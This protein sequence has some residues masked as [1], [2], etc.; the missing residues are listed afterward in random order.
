MNNSNLIIIED[1]IPRGNFTLVKFLRSKF[2]KLGDFYNGCVE[3]MDA[4]SCLRI[5]SEITEIPIE[6]LKERNRARRVVVARKL[7]MTLAYKATRDSLA[8]IAGLLNMDHASAIHS[9]KT[10][11]EDY[12]DWREEHRIYAEWINQVSEITGLKVSNILGGVQ[13]MADRDASI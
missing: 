6:S 13:R 11:N 8:H 4:K 12:H 2:L 3:T 5:V 1:I 7:Y 10:I 9:I